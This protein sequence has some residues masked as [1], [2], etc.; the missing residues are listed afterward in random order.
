MNHYYLEYILQN[1]R[2]ELEKV[3]SEHWKLQIE[4]KKKLSFRN[5]FTRKTAVQNN[6]VCCA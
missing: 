6:Q 5:L 4:E 2:K 3:S 1:H